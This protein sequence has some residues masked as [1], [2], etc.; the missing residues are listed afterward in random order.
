MNSAERREAILKELKE[1]DK[2]VSA[3]V[4]ANHLSVSR[5]IIVGDV[6]LLRA[7]GVDITATARGYVMGSTDG[8]LRRVA[9]CHTFDQLQR[10]LELMVDYGCTVEDVIVEH[11]V[12][13]E[14]TGRLDLS[15]RYDV[16]EFMDKVCAG[17]DKP[18]SALTG[19]IHIHTLRCTDDA[20]FERLLSALR[21][22]GFLIE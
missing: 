6:A 17:G 8:K 11:A 18:L 3:T 9:C 10:E 15:S 19:G 7:A 1:A 16:G 12:Y 21:D 2:P 4:L 14:L 13:G 20:A 22:E 5:Q